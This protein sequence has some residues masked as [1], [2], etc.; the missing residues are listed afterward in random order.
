MIKRLLTLAVGLLILSCLAGA[1]TASQPLDG[2]PWD[3][4]IWGGGGFSV[5]GGTADTHMLNAG[6][7]LGKVL[8]G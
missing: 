4:G 5:P 7:R 2:Q 1:Q 8:T 6:A 3:F